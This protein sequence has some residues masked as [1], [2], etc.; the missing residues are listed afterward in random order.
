MG[1]QGAIGINSAERGSEVGDF[2]HIQL[3]EVV[4]RGRGVRGPG[5]WLWP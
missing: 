3:K 5:L 2:C 4:R 1:D